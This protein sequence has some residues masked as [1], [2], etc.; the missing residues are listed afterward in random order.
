MNVKKYAVIALSV[1]MLM[2]GAS[3]GVQLATKVNA[4]DL[5]MTQSPAKSLIFSQNLIADVAEDVSPSVVNIDVE[6]IQEFQAYQQGFP[7]E[8]EFFRHFFGL[9]QMQPNPQQQPK[10][11]KRKSLGNGSG[12]I[13]SNDGYI[14][15]NNH[16]VKEADNITVTLKDARSFKATVIGTDAFSDLA[17]L[18]VEASNLKPAKLGDSSKLR[19]GEFALAI[20]SPLGYDHTVTLGIISALSRHLSS[21]NVDF[22]QTDASINPGNSGGPLVNINGEVV[23]INTAIAGIGTGIGFAIPINVAKEVSEQLINDGSIERPWIGI[24]M[25]SLDEQI[26]KSLGLPGNTQGVLVAQ[27]SP[28]GPAAMAGFQPGDIIQRIDG[29]LINSAEQIQDL[30]RSKKVNTDLNVQL[31]RN[32]EVQA[33]TLKTGQ[34]PGVQTL[35]R[36]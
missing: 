34:W 4:Q 9:P 10:T 22:I 19:P 33:L 26:L 29:R 35:N 3:L 6:N 13:I 8:D 36:R 11:F 15:T 31:L 20:G 25:R 30:V 23:G 14:L 7:F 18:K 12:V 5:L 1:S 24:A 17:V 28:Q 16:V 2:I 21:A 27:V 32:G